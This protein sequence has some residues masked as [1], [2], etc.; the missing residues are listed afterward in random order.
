[1]A[2]LG[3]A[4]PPDLLHL[5]GVLPSFP[6]PLRDGRVLE[7]GNHLRE[8]AIRFLLLHECGHVV[9]RHADANNNNTNSVQ[10]FDADELALSRRLALLKYERDAKIAGLLG[11]WLLLTVA[12]KA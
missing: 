9:L 8:C 3:I 12:P 11:A 10:E 4:H 5:G 6:N 2:I 7:A 1:M